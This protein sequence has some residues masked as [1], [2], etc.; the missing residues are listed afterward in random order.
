M[1]RARRGSSDLA[2]TADR[3]I[4]HGCLGDRYVVWVD[5]I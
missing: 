2:E 1:R 4:T 3:T 5:V